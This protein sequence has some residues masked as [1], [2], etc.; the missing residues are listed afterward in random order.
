MEMLFQYLS[1]PI[2]VFYF[3]C[4]F[5]VLLLNALQV[6]SRNNDN[7]FVSE[8]LN[9][10]RRIWH[11]IGILTTMSFSILLFSY[12]IKMEFGS[13]TKIPFG[14]QKGIINN[15]WT[16]YALLEGIKTKDGNAVY[17]TKFKIEDSRLC[18][19]FESDS[20]N[21][22]NN[23]FVYELNKN[24]LTEFKNT[25]DYNS[26]AKKNQLPIAQEFQNY[27]TNYDE[28][29]NGYRFWLF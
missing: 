25:S 11:I 24:K 10:K 19:N 18:G 1:N 23:Y 8:I 2:K 5:L 3:V 29:W 16:K 6:I 27:E 15:N 28:F 9:Q 13:Q 21:Y 22:S 7:L 12:F 20:C 26:F 14:Y 4:L 17:T